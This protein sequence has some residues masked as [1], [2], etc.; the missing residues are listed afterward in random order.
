MSTET[1]SPQW[2]KCGERMPTQ[3]DCW[4]LTLSGTNKKPT[5]LTPD[6]V[7]NTLQS[8]THWLDCPDPEPDDGFKEWWGTR[9]VSSICESRFMNRGSTVHPD[10]AHFVW[11]AAQNALRAQIGK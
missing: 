5:Y 10:D 3:N 1:K 4:Y 2:V 8:V 7:W 9:P 11:T 6:G